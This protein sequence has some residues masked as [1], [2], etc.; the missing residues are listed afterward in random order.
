MSL[1]TICSPPISSFALDV[2][3]GLSKTPKSI[4]SKHFYDDQGSRLF[5]QITQQPEYYLTRCELEILETHGRRLAAEFGTAP[6]R[7]IELGVGD[8]HKTAVLLR[9]LLERDAD[10]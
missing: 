3:E 8:G 6:L 2:V 4:P 10:V 1:E 5:Q 9:H 7:L